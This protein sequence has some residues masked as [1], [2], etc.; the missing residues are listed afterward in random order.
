MYFV[1]DIMCYDDSK[2]RVRNKPSYLIGK[3]MFTE[4]SKKGQTRRK[5]TEYLFFSFVQCHFAVSNTN[6]QSVFSDE[7]NFFCFSGFNNLYGHALWK[8]I[9]L[10]ETFDT[11]D[12][13]HTNIIMFV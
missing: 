8:Y 13:Q 9:Y 11:Y 3:A 10:T 2:L 12:S 5:T 7:W 4:T 1:T 6:A